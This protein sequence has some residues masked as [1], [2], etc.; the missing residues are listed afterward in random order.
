MMCPQLR[1]HPI[2]HEALE[3]RWPF[4]QVINC[5][6]RLCALPHIDQSLTVGFSQGGGITFGKKQF[7]E[8]DSTEIQQQ[9]TLPEAG[10]W[11]P[12]PEG[13]TG[14]HPTTSTTPVSK[15]LSS[16][17]GPYSPLPHHK[18][19][20]TLYSPLYSLYSSYSI[21]CILS[22]YL[23]Y[24]HHTYKMLPGTFC[25]ARVRRSQSAKHI[26]GTSSQNSRECRE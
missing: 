15:S 4:R 10:Q 22:L 11:V 19:H 8:K 2:P 26:L 3:L 9:P 1:A 24:G 23:R 25:I 12:P 20:S 21:P 18:S 17:P 16:P 13:V 5:D 14:Q 6:Q 7:S